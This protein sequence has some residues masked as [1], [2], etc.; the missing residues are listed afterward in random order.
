MENG[1]LMAKNLMDDY[2]SIGHLEKRAKRRV[3]HFA[4]EYLEMGTGEDEARDRNIT[5]L[6]EVLFLPQLMKGVLNPTVE[7]ELFGVKYD[8][9]IGIAPVGLSGLIWPGAEDALAATAADKRIPYMLS[10]VATAARRHTSS[11]PMTR[12]PQGQG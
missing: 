7:C 1:T 8:A 10:T 5:A 2:P 4:W 3:P 12:Y 9:P 11:F 6:Q